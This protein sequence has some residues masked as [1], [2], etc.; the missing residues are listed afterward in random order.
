MVIFTVETY[1]KVITGKSEGDML[2]YHKMDRWTVRLWENEMDRA[3]EDYAQWKILV[4]VEL[5]L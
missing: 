3:G 4:L 1:E 2:E 5:N